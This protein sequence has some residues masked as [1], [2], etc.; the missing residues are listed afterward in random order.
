MVAR[1]GDDLRWA[2]SGHQQEIEH[3]SNA[4]ATQVRVAETHNG[5]VGVVVSRAP[6][7]AFVVR[8]R[9]ELHC[10]ER[11]S[12]SW[13][14]VPVPAGADCDLDKFRWISTASSFRLQC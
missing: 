14:G 1:A 10:P 4:G 9:A 8:I 3:V 11:N 6:V 5:V 7:P 13:V 2:G 12:R